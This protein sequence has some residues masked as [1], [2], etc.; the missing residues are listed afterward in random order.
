[1]DDPKSF[2][3]N[4]EWTVDEYDSAIFLQ[5]PRVGFDCVVKRQT[6]SRSK[7]SLNT[8]KYSKLL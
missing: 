2:A 5:Y 4:G 6:M 1:M 8:V 3:A 7:N